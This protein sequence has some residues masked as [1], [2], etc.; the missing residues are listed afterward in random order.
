MA[1]RVDA[2]RRDLGGRRLAHSAL[3]PGSPE[4]GPYAAARRSDHSGL[5]GSARGRREGELEDA[6]RVLE[7]VAEELAQLAHP[8]AHGLRVHEQLGGDRVAAAVVQQ[9]GPQRLGELLGARRRAAPSGASTRARR[10]AAPR[11]RRSAPARR[12]A[13]RCRCRRPQRAGPAAARSYD[14]RTSSH[15]RAGPG[16][17]AAARER[18]EQRPAPAAVGVRDEQQHHAV[19]VRRRGG[20]SVDC[21]GLAGERVEHR[22]H[23]RLRHDHRGQRLGRRPVGALGGGLDRLGRRRRRAGARPAARAAAGG[24]GRWWPARRCGRRR[25]RPR[26]RRCRRRPARRT[27]P[28][29]R[30]RRRCAPRS[31]T[32]PA[33]RPGR[34][35]GTPRAA[36]RPT[37]RCAPRPGRAGRRRRRPGRWASGP[38]RSGRAASEMKPPRA[39]CTALR[40]VSPIGPLSASA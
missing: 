12:G 6:A 8:V 16:D 35:C 24:P 37:V 26:A 30:R 31:R 36:R 28:A 40:M 13:P 21:E 32:S 17:R 29:C 18:P 27:G 4:H 38:P 14:A 10:S 9:P 23:L 1:L 34:R 3:S 39:S 2:G 19:A 5:S 7:P 11:G 15:G 33:R 22:A 20:G 25:S